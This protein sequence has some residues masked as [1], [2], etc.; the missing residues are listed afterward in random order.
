M[1]Q[2]RDAP[3]GREKTKEELKR[4][5]KEIKSQNFY[6]RLGISMTASR[7]DVRKAY[8]EKSQEY[9]PGKHPGN[10]KHIYEEIQK[11]INHSYNTLS[12]KRKRAAY[13]FNVQNA[14]PALDQRRRQEQEARSRKSAA[15]KATNANPNAN[16]NTNPNPNPNA[17]PGGR[18]KQ[19]GPENPKTPEEEAKEYVKN[20]V[21]KFK[22]DEIL[23]P[24]FNALK[25]AQQMKIAQDLMR[26]MVDLVKSDAQTQYSEDLKDKKGF[27]KIR[28]TINKETDLKNLEAKAL[29]ALLGTDESKKLIA[30]NLSQLVDVTKDR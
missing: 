17:A 10:I 29:T 25:E 22:L 7:D 2:H 15:E 26:R 12:N 1:K 5:L 28:T 21:D 4:I 23:T 9:H 24:E 30:E 8:R 13:D 6:D 16:T 18:Q 27:G 3:P 19:T 11:L 14:D 20:F